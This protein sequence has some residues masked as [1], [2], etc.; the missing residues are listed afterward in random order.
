MTHQSWCD[1]LWRK[2]GK[3]LNLKLIGEFHTQNAEFIGTT[4]VPGRELALHG[5]NSE[6]HDEDV[7]PVTAKARNPECF[8]LCKLITFA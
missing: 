8:H 4:L 2:G 7:D 1:Y 3:P 6:S 5:S